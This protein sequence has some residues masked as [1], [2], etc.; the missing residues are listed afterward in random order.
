P[1]GRTASHLV[2]R[3]RVPVCLEAWEPVFPRYH[4]FESSRYWRILTT[5]ADRKQGAENCV[6]ALLRTP[7]FSTGNRARS[8][9]T[10]SNKKDRRLGKR[11]NGPRRED[12][13]PLLSSG[14]SLQCS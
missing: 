4:Y 12:I 11:T 7:L 6:V 10:I 9:P 2:S 5:R 13:C 8:S 1:Q 14:V 3:S